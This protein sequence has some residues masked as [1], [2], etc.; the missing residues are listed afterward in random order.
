MCTKRNADLNQSFLSIAL[1]LWKLLLKWGG[2]KTEHAV[3][4]ENIPLC[5]VAGKKTLSD[6]DHVLAC[7]ESA[8]LT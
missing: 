8:P 5:P 4:E 2:I 6:F 7:D 3:I 1:S